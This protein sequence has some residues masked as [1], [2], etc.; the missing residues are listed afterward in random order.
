MTP[1]DDELPEDHAGLLLL[2]AD[3]VVA[4]PAPSVAVP[5]LPGPRVVVIPDEAAAL[6]G[7]PG[8]GIDTHGR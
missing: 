5:L 3:V 4:A 7:E 2:A 8:L 1:R 6:V